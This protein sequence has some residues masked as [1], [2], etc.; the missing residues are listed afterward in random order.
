MMGRARSSSVNPMALSMARAGA[1]S[2]P[3]VSAA[4][5]RLA[6]S[7]GWPYGSGRSGTSSLL[8]SV[9]QFYGW[10]RGWGVV[11]GRPSGTC[12]GTAARARS[13]H[14]ERGRAQSGIR[15]TGVRGAT[16]PTAD[17]PLPYGPRMSRMLPRLHHWFL[18]LN[19]WFGVPMIKAGLS[20]AWGTP[21][22]GYFVLL[23]TRGR[24]SGE[25][26]EAPLGYG[27]AD[28]NVYV[29]AGFGRRTQ[30]LRNIQA[31]PN[32]E[33]LLPGRALR[34]LAEEVTDPTE[35]ARAC[36]RRRSAAA[37]WGRPRCDSIP[38]GQATRRC[39]WPPTGSRSSASRRPASRRDRGIPADGDGSRSTW[40]RGGWHGAGGC[41]E[42]AVP[43]GWVRACA[44]GR[45]RDPGPSDPEPPGRLPRS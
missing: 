11:L 1:R 27:L 29:M 43:P 12:P 38:D 36:G 35:R 21:Y 32:V 25:M 6:G 40:S 37:S 16:Q 45:A 31:D 18:L 28:G 42:P 4:E 30:W 8:G 20:P 9:R 34:G 24:T 39:W 22:G 10:R 3:S 13:W 41:A 15:D 23:R 33:V 2:G 26:R 5:C 19:R 7:V 44:R 17:E 14:G